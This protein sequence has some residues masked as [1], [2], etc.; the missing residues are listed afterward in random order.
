M[1][2]AEKTMDNTWSQNP[3]K[4]CFHIYSDGTLVHSLYDTEDDRV[5]MMNRIVLSAFSCH[6]KVI[7]P[8]VMR[9]HFHV[10]VRGEPEKIDKYLR[11]LKRLIVRYFRRIGKPEA[12]NNTIRIRAD[13]IL[14]DDEL[15]RKVIYI[16]R[17]CTE[18]GYPYLPENYPWGPGRVFFQTN[19]TAAIRR[20]V[21]DLSYREQCRL[22]RTRIKL[23]S[24]W[25]YDSKGMLIPYS[26]IDLNYIHGSIFT[27]IRQFIAFLSVKKKDLQEMEV[28]DKRRF[29]EQIDESALREQAEE[30]S[31]TL[32]GTTVSELSEANRLTLAM[33]FWND[34]KTFSIKQ[35]SRIVQ[36]DVSLLEAVLIQKDRF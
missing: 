18:A 36:A 30:D 20:R 8:E 6:L 17:N 35:L 32:F 9:T 4:D 10:I 33:R 24:E 13:S 25:E 5:F 12:V 1:T 3:V 19:E 31:R 34:R 23:P 14:D 21:G 22:F 26:Y 2:F 7:I 27:S 28:A 11:E 29:L 15:R 16:F